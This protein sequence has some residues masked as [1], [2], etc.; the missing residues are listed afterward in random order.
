VSRIAALRSEARDSGIEYRP[1]APHC[2]EHGIC[3][4][5]IC[6]GMAL[7]DLGGG[8][9][10]LYVG[11]GKNDLCPSARLAP[12]SRAFWRVGHGLERYLL[13]HPEF[14]KKVACRTAWFDQVGEIVQALEKGEE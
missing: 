13:A 6:K 5:P 3:D 10:C 4:L 2:C 7:T 1:Y 12:S 9:G 11:D 14:G 8:E